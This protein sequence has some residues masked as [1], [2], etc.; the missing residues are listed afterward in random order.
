MNANVGV[1]A[2]LQQSSVFTNLLFL[3][4]DFTFCLP[5]YN[6]MEDSLNWNLSILKKKR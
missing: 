1:Q 4:A 6:D 5:Y 3:D 2:A